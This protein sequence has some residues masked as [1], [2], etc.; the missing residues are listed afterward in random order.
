MKTQARPTGD[1]VASCPPLYTFFIRT[2]LS[3][4]LVTSRKYVPEKY[5]YIPMR[6]LTKSED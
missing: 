4:Q 2:L 1:G 6:N 5:A 3:A